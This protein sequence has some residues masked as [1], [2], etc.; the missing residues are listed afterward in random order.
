MAETKRQPRE[1]ISTRIDPDAH[2]MIEKTPRKLD[3]RT[4]CLTAIACPSG[5]AAVA[6]LSSDQRAL[7]RSAEA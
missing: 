7:P 3:C 5:S 2:A 4:I 1:S 6:V